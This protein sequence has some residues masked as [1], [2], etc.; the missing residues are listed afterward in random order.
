MKELNKDGTI[1]QKSFKDGWW[2]RYGES[3]FPRATISGKTHNYHVKGFDK[4]GESFWETFTTIKAARSFARK[5]GRL[6]TSLE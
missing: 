1:T 6:K 2:E 4:N 3:N 5:M